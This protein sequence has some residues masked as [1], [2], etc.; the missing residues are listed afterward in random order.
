MVRE[1]S[2]RAAVLLLAFPSFV[3][4]LILLHSA[5]SLTSHKQT[6]GE[7]GFQAAPGDTSESP[8]NETSQLLDWWEDWQVVQARRRSQL[9]SACIHVNRARVKTFSRL[10]IDRR[11]LYN[12]LVDDKHKVA[13]TN[14]KRIMMILSGRSIS[15]DPL[16]IRS[17]VPH[18]EGVLTRLSGMGTDLPVLGYKLRTYTK[19][20]LVRHPMERLVSAYRN[21]LVRNS[22][23]STDFKKRFGISILKKYRKGQGHLNESTSGH[24]VTFSEFV[25]YLTDTGK[26]NYWTL[27]EH[28]APYLEL[29]HP[30]TIKYNIIGKYETLEEDAEYI[31]RMIGA[32]PSLHFPPI[33]TSKT[34]SFVSAYFASLTDTLQRRLYEMY[35]HD[36]K[37]FQYDL[38]N[39]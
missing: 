1:V 23:S 6:S 28:W 26:A 33:V 16:S 8:D 12:L 18:E 17:D 34:A 31:L 10:L 25:S 13:C 3:C 27:N 20:L 36:F 22:T 37:L 2:W 19:F 5:P 15:T 24:G 4:Y 11:Y 32:P 39:Y 29:C 14:W 30:C 21:K 35:K 38:H 7:G 9:R